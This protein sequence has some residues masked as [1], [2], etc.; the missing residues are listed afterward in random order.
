MAWIVNG[1][2]EAERAGAHMVEDEVMYAITPRT[3]ALEYNQYRAC[4][5]DTNP[6]EAPDR[7]AQMSPEEQ[8]AHVTA[9]RNR[10]EMTKKG[11]GA[12]LW[13][14]F[15]ATDRELEEER[16]EQTQ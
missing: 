5:E 4:Q 15:D 3:L 8:E 2:G 9:M 1:R 10:I 16:K 14:L 6:R 11:T 7:W 13:D 12:E